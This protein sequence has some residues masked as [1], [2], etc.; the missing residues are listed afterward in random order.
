MK[1]TLALVGVLA[2]ALSGCASTPS[3]EGNRTECEVLKKQGQP[4]PEECGRVAEPHPY[5][6]M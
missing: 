1:R 2:A 3:M 5:N 4:L 6:S